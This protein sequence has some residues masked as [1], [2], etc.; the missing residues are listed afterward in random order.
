MEGRLKA[1]W[2]S[3]HL[4]RVR[5]NAHEGLLVLT[6]TLGFLLRINSWLGHHISF[7]Y[8][9][10]MWAMRLLHL[11]LLDLSIR[12]IGFM[13]L[14][15]LLVHAF[16][17]TEVWFRFLPAVG[18]IGSLLLMPYV[19]SQL[20]RS[21]WLQLLL[22]F[23]FAINPALID[24]ANEFKPYSLEVLIHL[25]PIALY[26]RFKQTG[27]RGWFYALLASLPLGF[28]LA[29]NLTFAYPGVLLLCLFTAWHSKDRR[30]LVAATLLSGMACVGTVTAIVYKLA[31]SHINQEE[32]PKTTGATST[33]SFTSETPTRVASI[34]RSRSS[35]T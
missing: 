12:P 8:D 2:A 30:R 11:S 19:A 5:E 10:S 34:G 35:T 20:L 6:L 3:P 25:V 33:T 21:K 26:L 29:Y 17:A 27:E 14:T 18:A 16:G 9:E 15:R 28:L 32:K 7:W 24:Y 23:L 13:W 22:V 4:A 31:L 1:A